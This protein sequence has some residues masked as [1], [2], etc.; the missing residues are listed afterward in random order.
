VCSMYS[1]ITSLLASA[2]CT[3]RQRQRRRRQAQ[4]FP[5][6]GRWGVGVAAGRTAR[7]RLR[8]RGHALGGRRPLLQQGAHPRAIAGGEIEGDEVQPSCAGVTIP[9]WCVPRNATTRSRVGAGVDGSAEQA[10]APAPASTAP[11]PTP[12]PSRRRRENPSLTT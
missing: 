10:T 7:R 9:A 5:G 1:I 12:Q 6:V 2:R 4:C 8:A 3:E 11:V